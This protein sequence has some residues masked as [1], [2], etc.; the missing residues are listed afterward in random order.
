MARVTDATRRQVA[1]MLRNRDLTEGMDDPARL[2]GLS[3]EQVMEA[4]AFHL[5]TCLLPAFHRTETMGFEPMLDALADLIDPD[6][7]R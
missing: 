2:H 4:M 5:Q 7:G 6:G 1:S 3:R